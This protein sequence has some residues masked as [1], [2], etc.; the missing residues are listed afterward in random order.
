MVD[1]AATGPDRRRAI[2]ALAVAVAVTAGAVLA[3]TGAIR[4]ERGAPVAPPTMQASA[5]TDELATPVIL[6]PVPAPSPTEPT[7]DAVVAVVAFWSSE[8]GVT[9]AALAR[10]VAGDDPA[11]PAVVVQAS[12][13]APL[14]AALDVSPGPKIRTGSAAQVRAAVR[15][16]PGVI[17]ILRAKDV[18]PDVRVLAVDGVDLF[19]V[20]R[21]RDLSRWPLLVATDSDAGTAAFDPAR[22]WTLV[23][24]GDVMLDREVYQQSVVGGKGPDWP[25]NGG[26]ARIVGQVCCD[27][28]GGLLP[29]A[30]RT[31]DAGAVRALFERADLA[32]VNLEGPAP[33]DF[34][35]H[36]DGF[37][38]TMDPTLLVG[39][40]DA[41][42]DF[43]SLGNNHVGNAGPAAVAQTIRHLD[44]L[45]IGHAGAGSGLSAARQPAWFTVDGLRI[46]VLAYNGTGL[47]V[48]ATATRAGAAPLVASQVAADVRAARSAGADLVVVWPHWGT[49][50]TATTTPQ[51][52]DLARTMAAAGADLIIGDH[53]HWAG[54]LQAIGSSLVL[55]DLGDFIFDLVHSA[56]TEE[57]LIVELTFEGTR[58]MQVELR[59]TLS[60]DRSQP[61]LLEPSG[62]GRVVL[63]QVREAS[64]DLLDW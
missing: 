49:E 27:D 61:N 13:L 8:R 56:Q 21:L 51:Q 35:Y 55:Y 4:G 62:D 19:G 38:F 25:W 17:G 11:H 5:P 12:E 53:G 7:R 52:R 14:A 44:A 31:G 39:L 33:A 42:I 16:Q 36:P 9:R 64:R 40:R 50:Y 2:G 60:L 45:G 10:A 58:L 37:V 30:E 46:A 15:G 34:T 63:D 41:G 18:T 24:A 59:P 22:T 29:V 20:D 1:S 32:M 54:P 3:A 57:A 47:G 28:Y 48:N 26:T 6:Q 43:A 23:A